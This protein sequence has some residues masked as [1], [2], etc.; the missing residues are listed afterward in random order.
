VRRSDKKPRSREAFAAVFEEQT[1]RFSAF[2][3]LGITSKEETSPASGQVQAIRPDRQGQVLRSDSPGEIQGL[4]SRMITRTPELRTV[5]QETPRPAQALRPDRQGQALT[6]E[7]PA[8]GQTLDPQQAQ[9]PDGLGLHQT[10]RPASGQTAKPIG[11]LVPSL[12]RPDP[13]PR[14]VEDS[15]L[16]APLQWAVWQTLQGV[17]ETGH[18][19]SYRAIAK[20]T[21]ST[22]DGVRKAVRVLEKEGVIIRKETVRTAEE[23]GFRVAVNPNAKV[24]RGTLNEAKAILK[25]GLTLGQ[26]SDRQG[27]ILRPDGLR[28]FVCKN[29]NIKQTDLA[30]LLRIPPL[31]WKIREQTLIQIADA[32]PDMT[33]IEFRLSLSYLVSQAQQTKTE[34]RNHNAWVKAAF[35]KNGKPLV[36]EREIEA[37]Y[38]KVPLRLEHPRETGQGNTEDLALLRR[39]LACGPGEREEI[40]R[41]AHEKVTPLLNVIAEDKRAGVIEEARLV[42]VREYF[43]T[44]R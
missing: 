3:L 23:Q 24:R 31:D 15:I 29:L 38:E 14:A 13:R 6:T 2:E 7:S 4:D 12:L 30:Q 18:V 19:T 36:T 20:Q 1:R 11:P 32:L 44:K 17:A 33:A 22:I 10:V 8:S 9:T 39:Y 41:R 28:M 35:E 27:L 34:I 21:N 40:D 37:R 42:A 43:S 5:P 26:T 25:R 16:L